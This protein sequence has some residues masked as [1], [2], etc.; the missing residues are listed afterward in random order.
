MRLLIADMLL[1]GADNFFKSYYYFF[2]YE[3]CS[4]NLQKDVTLCGLFNF[5]KCL[6]KGVV[7]NWFKHV[8]LIVLK[9]LMQWPYIAMMASSTCTMQVEWVNRNRFTVWDLHC[10]TVSS[11]LLC[12]LAIYIQCST[13]VKRITFVITLDVLGQWS[14]S[15]LYYLSLSGLTHD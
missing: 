1:W 10:L 12:L 7:N 14:P 6:L 15:V 5:K 11:L 8:T 9:W 13:S 3:G 4:A 2:Q